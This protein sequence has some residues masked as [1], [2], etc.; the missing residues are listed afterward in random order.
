MARSDHNATAHPLLGAGR[1]WCALT[2]QVSAL[3]LAALL[4][5]PVARGAE[6]AKTPATAAVR[7]AQVAIADF[8]GDQLPDLASIETGRVGS[9]STDYW[10]QLQ[11]TDSGRQSIHLVAPSGGLLIEARDVNGDHAIDLVLST[12]LFRQPVAVLLNDGHG[13]FSRAE[14]SDFPGAFEDS[15]GSWHSSSQQESEPAG[16]PPEG[17]SG[18]CSEA[19]SLPDVRGPTNCLVASTAGFLPDSLLT[20]HAGRAPPSQVLS[21]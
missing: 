19:T 6:D 7:N 17:R 1:L 20:S 8:D 16:I 14:P 13:R 5:A 3:V 2:L 10:I 18:N 12:V 15:S 9:I 21:L 4:C 11:L